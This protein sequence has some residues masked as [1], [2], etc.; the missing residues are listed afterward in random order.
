M[1]NL[2]IQS[3]LILTASS[4]IWLSWAFP[5]ST[6]REG[7]DPN[8]WVAPES[9]HGPFPEDPVILSPS[10][11][12][13]PSLPAPKSVAQLEKRAIT[14]RVPG[15]RVILE[16]TVT[17]PDARTMAWNNIKTL[18]DSGNIALDIAAHMAGGPRFP[19]LRPAFGWA[20]AGLSIIVRRSTDEYTPGGRFRWD[21]AKAVY[22]GVEF[23]IQQMGYRETKF[24]IIRYRRFETNPQIGSGNITFEDLAVLE[25]RSSATS[26]ASLAGAPEPKDIR[27]PSGITLSA[28]NSIITRRDATNSDDIHFSALVPKANILI[29]FRNMHNAAPVPPSHADCLLV[30]AIKLITNRAKAGPGGWRTPNLEDRISTTFNGLALEI[31]DDSS[32]ETPD[33]RMDLGEVEDVYRGLKINL[34]KLGNR[35]AVM[36]VYR[37]LSIWVLK[38]HIG[39]AYLRVVGTVVPGARCPV[40]EGMDGNGTA[41]A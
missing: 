7:T 35:E 31:F 21:E 4:L 13:T 3:L 9:R 34:G 27:T 6:I 5:S 2:D 24:K 12:F 8:L 33:R 41:Q 18:L 28:P 22:M 15:T 14:Y 32:V 25:G 1:R 40:L 30:S 19:M 20:N 16:L 23:V 37:K 36:V 39:T 17:G 11:P 26:L 29:N 38:H 10:S